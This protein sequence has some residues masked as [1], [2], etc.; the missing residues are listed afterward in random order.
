MAAG[1]EAPRINALDFGLLEPGTAH[2]AP[3]TMTPSL[4]KPDRID[5]RI[6]AHLQI[7]GRITNVELAEV[8][9]LSASPA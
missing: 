1:I 5:L 2:A 7:H 3:P 8:V 4:P 9:G 6:P